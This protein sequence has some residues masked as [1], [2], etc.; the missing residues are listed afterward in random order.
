MQTARKRSLE[1]AHFT[2]TRTHVYTLYRHIYNVKITVE[3]DCEKSAFYSDI[4]ATDKG[5]KEDNDVSKEE[6]TFRHVSHV[7]SH[8][9]PFLPASVLSCTRGMK[10]GE[11][12]RRFKT[13][14]F[15]RTP[16]G[17]LTLK[18]AR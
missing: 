6:D 8:V 5:D 12:D 1:F 18:K 15:A 7:S 14:V 2:H 17:V 10:G 13:Q 11:P 9:L 16:S 3:H 4:F